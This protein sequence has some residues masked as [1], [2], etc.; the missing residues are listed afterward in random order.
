M[1]HFAY[2]LL[3][4]K[5]TTSVAFLLK[6]IFIYFYYQQNFNISGVILGILIVQN[7]HQPPITFAIAAIAYTTEVSTAKLKIAAISIPQTAIYTHKIMIDTINKI[8]I[9]NT[10]GISLVAKLTT[11]FQNLGVIVL[12]KNFHNQT[13][14]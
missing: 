14:G 5:N 3:Y 4:V 8:K 9:L 11:P 10:I 2:F 6:L 7:S 13:T 1:S 12:Y